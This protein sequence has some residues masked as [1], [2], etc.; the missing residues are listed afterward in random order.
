MQKLTDY[1]VFARYAPCLR[2]R[3]SIPKD[4][5]GVMQARERIY[6]SRQK[7]RERRSRIFL[8]IVFF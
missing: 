7:I 5:A 1:N 3:G 2:G 6:P 4:D 8:F